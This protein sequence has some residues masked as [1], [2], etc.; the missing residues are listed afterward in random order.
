MYFEIKT[1]QAKSYTARSIV[2]Y[3]IGLR[4]HTNFLFTKLGNLQQETF[5]KFSSKRAGVKFEEE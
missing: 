2:R 4:M 1:K 3:K 5:N